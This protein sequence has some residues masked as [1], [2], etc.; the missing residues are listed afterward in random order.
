MTDESEEAALMLIAGIDFHLSVVQRR[1]AAMEDGMV[2]IYNNLKY[3]ENYHTWEWTVRQCLS[4]AALSTN[5][6]RQ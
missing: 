6:A 2:F 4:R 3:K 5:P 1:R